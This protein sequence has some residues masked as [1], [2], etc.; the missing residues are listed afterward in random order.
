MGAHSAQ[1]NFYLKLRYFL[2]LCMFPVKAQP[3]V[4]QSFPLIVWHLAPGTPQSSYCNR[5]KEMKFS[6]YDGSDLLFFFFTI[7]TNHFTLFL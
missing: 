6:W 2:I 5:K 1:K 7:S 4:G 3:L